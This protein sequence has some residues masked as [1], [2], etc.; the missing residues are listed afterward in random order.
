MKRNV[1]AA[2][3]AAGLLSSAAAQA[4]GTYVNV[5]VGRSE[6][7][8]DG[9]SENKTAISL[10][11]GQSL[12]DNWGYEVGYLNFGNLSD[13]MSDGVETVSMKLRVQSIYAAAVGTLPVSD[14]FSLF[15][16]AGLAV[17]RAKASAAYTDGIVTESESE[18]ET[19]VGPMVGVG[20]AYNFTKQV[21]ATA[22]YRYFHEV[23]DGG[24]K[25]SALTAGIRYSF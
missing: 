15:A 13:S 25:A 4:E 1:L 20:F 5:G 18:S 11:F 7:K 23:I 16:K 24:V 17:N 21:A 9:D 22:E 8:L 2:L 6:Y 19:K 10:A 12:G 3:I 14:S